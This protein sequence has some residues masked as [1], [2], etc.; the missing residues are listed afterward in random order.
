MRL[1]KNHRSGTYRPL[2][3]HVNL[4]QEVL[5]GLPWLLRAHQHRQILGH[6]AGLH[7]LDA[8]PFQGLRKVRDRRGAVQFTS[9]REALGPGENRGNRI[10]RGWPA[11]LMFAIVPGDGPVRRLCFD[12]LAV[13][14]HQ[15]RGH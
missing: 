9:V 15:H 1:R 14:S 10:S 2:Q 4:S 13:R 8:D 7:G 5:G 12:G 11:L 6:F 3:V